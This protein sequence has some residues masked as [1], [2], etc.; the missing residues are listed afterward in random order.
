VAD[1]LPSAQ[2]GNGSVVG[3]AAIAF[4]EDQ[5]YVLLQGAGCS[6]GHPETPNGIVRVN[7]DGT[8]ALVAD[9]S[10]FWQE[11]AFASPESDDFEPDGDPYSMISVD[12]DLYVVEANHGEVD[13]VSFDENGTVVHI[14]RVVDVSK[15]EGHAVPTALAS[16]L[17]KLSL[18]N[19]QTFPVVLGSSKVWSLEGDGDFS[20]WAGGVTAVLGLVFHKRHPYALETTTAPGPPTPGTEDIVAV[21]PQGVTPIASGLAFPTAMIHGW[22]QALYVSN[23]GFGPPGLGEILRVKLP[24]SPDADHDR[25]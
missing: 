20:I 1:G 22:N 3:A 4:I 11:N 21:T 7:Q 10:A 18:S 6:H 24:K 15:T 19:L 2:A 12:G 16:H 5:R 25:R 23:H 9:L 8:W 13:R 17:G 14:E